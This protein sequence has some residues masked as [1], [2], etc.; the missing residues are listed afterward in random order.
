[1][2]TCIVPG[3]TLSGEAETHI[4][5]PTA[6]EITEI[7]VDKAQR[8][9]VITEQATPLRTFAGYR[10][11]PPEVYHEKHLTNAG[12]G[13]VLSSDYEGV[14]FSDGRVV[15]RWQTEF[16]SISIWDSYYSFFHVHGHPEYG[17]VILFADG[18]PPPKTCC[19]HPG[20]GMCFCDCHDTGRKG[21]V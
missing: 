16:S 11:L 17:T 2:S 10:P 9:T 3:C 14:V 18:E 20:T 13:D 6:S 19:K 8:V 15:I 7:A 1:M 12:I 4:H 21:R 5:L